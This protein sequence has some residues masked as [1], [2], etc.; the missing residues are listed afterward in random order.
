MPV[1]PGPPPAQL[2]GWE[3]LSG[4]ELG[5]LLVRSPRLLAAPRGDAPV[6]VLPGY[7]ADDASTLPLRWFLGRLGHEVHG[8]ALGRNRGDV[9][10][11]M[12]RVARVVTELAERRGEPV[13]LVG[14]SLGGVLARETARDQ[15]ETVAQVITLGTPVVG[16]PA[17]TRLGARYDAAALARIDA[18]IRS[19]SRVPISVPL[20]IVY[21]RR[22]GIVNWRA[23]IDRDNPQ[24]QHVEVS[25]SHL[26]MG[27]DPKVWEL[28]AARLAPA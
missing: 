7:G 28:V 16:G 25:S 11:L 21:S 18:G 2:L 1:A 9:P 22:D 17:H 5:R 19:R 24:A 6:V 3:A 14:Q 10:A 26:G 8:W 27:I 12:P 4:L 20:T 23:C 13:H 15:P